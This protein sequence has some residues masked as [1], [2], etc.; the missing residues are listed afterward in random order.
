MTK[1]QLTILNKYIEFKG[2]DISKFT[3]SDWGRYRKRTLELLERGSAEEVVEGMVWLKDWVNGRTWTLETLDKH[4]LEYLKNKKSV[5][6]K[7]DYASETDELLRKMGA[8]K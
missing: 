5:V 7:R 8:I 6:R 2:F 3:R 1:E 4:W